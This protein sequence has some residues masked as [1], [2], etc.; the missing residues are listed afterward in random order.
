MAQRDFFDQL[1]ALSIVSPA[2]VKITLADLLQTLKHA[3]LRKLEDDASKDMDSMEQQE[4]EMLGGNKGLPTYVAL[5]AEKDEVF[6]FL[7]ESR[8]LT[9]NQWDEEY[10][11]TCLHYVSA[12]RGCAPRRRN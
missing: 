12:P 8:L 2:K 6:K 9:E 1:V 4:L 10:K 3:A 11:R 7:L 5:Y